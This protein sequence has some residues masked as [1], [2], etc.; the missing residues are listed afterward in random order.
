MSV[1]SNVDA[2][3]S[4]AREKDSPAVRHQ[5]STEKSFSF[6]NIKHTDRPHV[7]KIS[8]MKVSLISFSLTY[9][10]SSS[11]AFTTPGKATLSF[12]RPTPLFSSAAQ[13]IQD[14]LA[15]SKQFG[16]S[17]PQARVAWDIVEEIN[18]SN[19][20]AAYQGGGISDQEYKTKI[21][22]LSQLLEQERAKL[23]A[24]KTLAL[25]IRNIK[26]STPDLTAPAQDATAIQAALNEAKV[27]TEK[28]GVHSKESKL[29]YEAVEEIASSDNSA[30]MKGTLDEEC[31]VEALE[32]C[33]VLEELENAINLEKSRYTGRY[34]G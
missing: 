26:L 28:F 5:T 10:L 24:V 14:A 20:S 1:C 4:H 31:L 2:R 32:A 23:E 30:A 21:D 11:L 8:K 18:A 15:A 33:A 17:S 9:Y 13:A 34:H 27:I 22:A 6:D 19:N 7:R 3:A 29:A 25:D 12:R 16:P